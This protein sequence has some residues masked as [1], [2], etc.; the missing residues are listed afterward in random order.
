MNCIHWISFFPFRDWHIPNLIA[1]YILA[2]QRQ[3]HGKYPPCLWTPLNHQGSLHQTNLSHVCRRFIR[4]FYFAVPSF[5]HNTFET[6]TNYVI[7]K[8][9]W[10]KVRYYKLA[11]RFE[12]RCF[13][14]L[15]TAIVYQMWIHSYSSFCP[16]SSASPLTLPPHP[17]SPTPLRLPISFPPTYF[18]HLPFPNF[19]SKQSLL[20]HC[21]DSATREKL[22]CLQRHLDYLQTSTSGLEGKASM[23]GAIK[24]EV[25]VSFMVSVNFRLFFG[26]LFYALD[27]CLLEYLLALFLHKH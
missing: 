8:V 10:R 11:K 20:L 16:L 25:R 7:R 21:G 12:W 1:T 18:F 6:H 22:T 26:W 5:K 15:T 3:S 17:L 13:V 27:V 24:Q 2:Y 23:L 19:L 9:T 4:N 14:S